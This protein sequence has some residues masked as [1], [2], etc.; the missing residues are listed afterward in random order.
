MVQKYHSFNKPIFAKRIDMKVLI[1]ANEEQ[2]KEITNE[3]YAADNNLVFVSK[4][5]EVKEDFDAFLILNTDISEVD[6]SLFGDKFV[7]VNEVIR[8]N[9]ELQLPG[10]VFRLIGWPG[11]LSRPLWELSGKKDRE[12]EK[13]IS[14]LGRQTVFVADIPGLVSASVVSMI[15]NEAHIA[16]EEN[17]SSENEIDYAMKLGTNYPLGPFAWAE[18]IGKQNVNNLLK[19]LSQDFLRYQPSDLLK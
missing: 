7:F 16:K 19:R 15:I 13:V 6:L 14:L 11:F 2:Q 8:T 4:V 12:A 1:C 17:I 9:Y 10:N 5:P 18:R 3:F